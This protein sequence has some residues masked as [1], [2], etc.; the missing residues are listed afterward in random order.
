MD[1]IMSRD[2]RELK[3]RTLY[4]FILVAT[5]FLLGILLGYYLNEKR[6]ESTEGLGKE[7]S[8]SIDDIELINGISNN[9]CINKD[10]LNA[11]SE[12]LD[13][14]A[15]KLSYLEERLGKESAKII[16]LKKPYTI[17][18]LK[19]YLAIEE[20][21][22]KCNE[23]YVTILFFYSNKKDEIGL[24]ENEAI[25]LSYIK[26]KFENV[27]IYALDLNLDLQIINQLKHRYN[28]TKAPALVINGLVYGYL[29]KDELENEVKKQKIRS[30]S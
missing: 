5:I 18:M 14:Y 13:K 20:Q 15:I 4:V 27:M 16:E 28:I 22:E 21:K 6:I 7:I 8:I 23:D 19:H 17:L 1:K 12:Q 25:I 26:K 3:L 9:P 24:S 2:F 10:Y 11:L 29:S 30:I